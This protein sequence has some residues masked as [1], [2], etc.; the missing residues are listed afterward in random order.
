[1]FIL[2][3]VASAVANRA[4]DPLLTSVARDF[5]VPITTAA[6]LSSAYALPSALGQ[7]LL[8]PIGDHYGKTRVLR[9]C[10]WVMALAITAC[11][12]APALESLL[13]LRFISGLAA[14]GVTPVAMAIIGDRVAPQHR[15]MAIARFLTAS[16][17]GQIFGASLAGILADSFSWRGVFVLMAAPALLAAIGATLVFRETQPSRAKERFQVS[18]AIESYRKVFGNPKSF[19]CFGGVFVES[20]AMFGVTPYIGEMLERNALGGPTQAGLVLGG[21]GIGGVTYG[22]TLKYILPHLARTTMMQIGGLVS[23]LGLGSLGL[24]MPWGVTMVLFAVSG[25]GFMLMHNSIQTEVA[26]IAPDA[27]A[28][29]FSMHAF[30]FFS[31]QAIGPVIFGF[32]LH[33]VGP[34][35]IVLNMAMLAATGLVVGHL[36]KRAGTKLT[37]G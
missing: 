24:G 12:F 16:L 18:N 32:G 27:R 28:S 9:I 26:D 1:M 37:T 34:S 13:G 33:T 25:F 31:G 21:I 35:I 8:G 29:A 14:G 6:L 11:V 5:M 22:L 36:F 2:I 19:Y 3:G 30:S 20:I 10:L 4:V 7:P 15:Q 23:V 17:T